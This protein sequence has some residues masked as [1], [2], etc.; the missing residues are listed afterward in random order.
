MRWRERH[1]PATSPQAHPGPHLRATHSALTEHDAEAASRIV[2]REHALGRHCEAGP[3]LQARRVLDANRAIDFNRVHLRRADPLQQGAGA[4]GASEFL[5]DLDVRFVL[6]QVVGVPGQSGRDTLDDEWCHCSS[7]FQKISSQ[8]ADAREDIADDLRELQSRRLEHV[9]S[10]LAHVTPRLQIMVE[11]PVE[12]FRGE[13]AVVLVHT[14]TLQEGRSLRVGRHVLADETGAQLPQVHVHRLLAEV[15]RL[16]G[17]L[18]RPIGERHELSDAYRRYVTAPQRG[19]FFDHARKPR[20]ARRHT[21]APSLRAPQSR[22]PDTRTQFIDASG[23]A[24][25]KKETN[26][27]VLLPQHIDHIVDIFAAKADVQYVATSVDHQAIAE[28]DYNLSVSSYVEAE[29]TREVIDIAKLNSE[30]AQ[31]VKRI[32]TLRADIDEII[33]Q[34]EA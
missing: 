2:P 11:D 25:Y 26:N 14:G 28:N 13:P 8:G 27:N 6:I 5:I 10:D 33:K 3:A 21:R 12:H 7:S 31:T 19:G 23:E 30:V 9:E 17:L 32:D 24:F 16:E 4:S 15:H 34:L 20:Y 22:P 18:G 1:A 29:D